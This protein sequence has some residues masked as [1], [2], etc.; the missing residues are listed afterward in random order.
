MRRCLKEAA[1]IGKAER[2]LRLRDNGD[3]H[4]IGIFGSL[5]GVLVGCLVAG[6]RSTARRHTEL[7]EERQNAIG[8]ALRGGS[9]S[10]VRAV[11]REAGRVGVHEIL[12]ATGALG[13]GGCRVA[14]GS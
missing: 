11:L 4:A 5:L 8:A 7:G 6:C 13:A 12:E 1:V 2:Q 3:D 10:R 14:G 9:C